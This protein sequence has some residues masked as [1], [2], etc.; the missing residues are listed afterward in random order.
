[1]SATMQDLTDRQ[2]ITDLVS[3]LGIALDEG[4]F[5]DLRSL[6]A[7][8][9]TARTP[10][11]TARG[12]EAVVAQARRN[13]RPDQPIQHLITNLVVDLDGDR[14]R[15]RA[16]LVVHFGTEPGDLDPGE[17][18]A[19]DATAPSAARPLP[20]PPLRYTVG[21]VYDF[22]FIRTATGWLFTG[23]VAIP[24]WTAGTRPD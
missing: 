24:L 21:E 11:G 23:I 12:H 20:A 15:A 16:N 13:H 8:D 17:P 5:D 7:D 1:M 9:A 19:A 4:R 2:A 3:R 22:A 14:A 10:G 6:L 18:G